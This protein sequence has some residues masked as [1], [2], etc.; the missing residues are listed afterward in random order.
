M[1]IDNQTIKETFGE[2]LDNRKHG[3]STTTFYIEHDKKLSERTNVT[4]KNIDTSTKILRAAIG[5]PHRIY[6][7]PLQ[8]AIAVKGFENWCEEKNVAPSYAALAYYLNISK[9]T[10]I[11]YTKDTTPYTCYSLVD[12]ITEEYLYS[13]NDKEKL[14]K[15]IDIHYLVENVGENKAVTHRELK[16]VGYIKHGLE[17][18]DRVT[19]I[20]DKIDTGEYGIDVCD[21]TFAQVLAPV[22][23]LLEMVNINKAEVARNPAWHIFL[24]KNNFG[25]TRQYVDQVQQQVSVVNPLDEMSDEEII[26]VAQNR[27]IE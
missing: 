7:N 21:I 17:T 19:A 26:R 9:D 2:D 16:P 22:N 5:Q 6:K 14:D 18:Y 27:P 10:L 1:D 20:R 3:K 25:N 23:N 11:N 13:T 24:A 15:Y 12:N 4:P 8:F